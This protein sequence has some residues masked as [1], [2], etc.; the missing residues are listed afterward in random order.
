MIEIWQVSIRVH[1][2]SLTDPVQTS[3]L[4]IHTGNLSK[5]EPGLC[6]GVF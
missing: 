1:F 6:V 2:K 3:G 5:Q 4:L